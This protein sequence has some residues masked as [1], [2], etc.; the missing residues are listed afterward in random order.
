MYT[1][2]PSHCVELCR[3][4]H[5]LILS[6]TSISVP[7][8]RPPSPNGHLLPRVPSDKGVPIYSSVRSQ[9]FLCISE[10]HQRPSTTPLTPNPSPRWA[11]VR[12]FALLKSD[13]GPLMFTADGPS[14]RGDGSPGIRTPHTVGL[15]R[16]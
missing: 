10:R 11:A 16:R 5:P 3:H 15:S 6:K 8:G 12:A 7:Y 13:C 1:P 14:G 9:P 2:S 4:S